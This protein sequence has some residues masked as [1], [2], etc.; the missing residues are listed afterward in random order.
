MAII[1][2]VWLYRLVRARTNLVNLLHYGRY[3]VILLCNCDCYMSKSITMQ[4]PL[5][6]QTC[7]KREQNNGSEGKFG[8]SGSCMPAVNVGLKKMKSP[9]ILR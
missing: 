3:K 2:D 6:P 8:E 5:G 1:Y 7:R 4:S 9:Y